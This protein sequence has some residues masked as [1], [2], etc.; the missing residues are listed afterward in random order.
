MIHSKPGKKHLISG[1]EL[2]TG[3]P[4]EQ[5]ARGTSDDPSVRINGGNLGYFTVFPDD[6]AI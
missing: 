1:K 6:N 5:V 4:F 3:E 2:L